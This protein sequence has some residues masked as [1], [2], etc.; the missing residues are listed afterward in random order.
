M[1]D[2]S[3]TT[4]SMSTMMM[5]TYLHFTPGDTL[6]FDS[7]APA[8]GG[9]IFGACLLF[10]SSRSVTATCVLHA[11]VSSALLFRAYHFAVDNDGSS[12]PKLPA[13]EVHASAVATNQF[14]LSHELSRG[15]L[16]GLQ[17]TIHYLLMLVVMTF[18]A[19]FLSA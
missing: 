17:T 7:I 8:S 12:I 15:V 3:N 5:K 14:I 11:V 10:S 6:L 19:S 18:N 1:T 16:S 4:T 2:T 9:A 13:S